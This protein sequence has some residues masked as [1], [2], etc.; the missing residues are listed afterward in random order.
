MRATEL[1]RWMAA[2]AA[3]MAFLYVCIQAFKNV[4]SLFSPVLQSN[5]CEAGSFPFVKLFG[6]SFGVLLGDGGDVKPRLLVRSPN[7]FRGLN[8]FQII[9]RT[10]RYGDS[11]GA[12]FP[13]RKNL[14]AAART[15]LADKVITRRKFGKHSSDSHRALGKNGSNKK[16]R[17]CQPLAILAMA[18]PHVDWSAG[19]HVGYGS[20]KALAGPGD[21]CRVSMKHCVH[22]AAH[23]NAV[24]C[25]I[26][27][28]ARAGTVP[29]GRKL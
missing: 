6:E 20:A 2:K 4:V 10:Q 26:Q 8:S 19:H 12:A 16:G 24:A 5:P 11:S 23:P 18:Y 21:R 17:T 7:V 1:N 14:A 28:P 22:N 9:E 25:Q 27:T 3:L 15:K 29:A 13:L